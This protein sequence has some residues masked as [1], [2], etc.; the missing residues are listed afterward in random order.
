MALILLSI[1]YLTVPALILY[2]CKKSSLIRKI[3]SIVVAYGVGILMGLSGLLPDGSAQLQDIFISG[4]I[5]LAIPLLLFPTK[6]SEW[7]ELAGPTLKALAVGMFS[8][9]LTVFIGYFIFKPDESQEFWKVGALLIGVY[10]GGTPN[11]ASLKVMLDV[12]NDTYLVVHSYDMIFGSI[13]FFFLITIGHRFFLKILPPFR[14]KSGRKIVYHEEEPIFDKLFQKEATLPLLKVFGLALLIL[15]VSAGLASL[16]PESYFMIVVILGL[17]TLALAASLIPGVNKIEKSFDLGMYFIL[18][19]SVSVASMVNLNDLIHASIN[20]MFYPAFVIF[21]SLLVQTIISRFTKTDADTLM[22]TST[23][24]ICSPPF[25]PVV[26]SAIK[27]RNILVP[28]ITVGVIGYAVGN[29]LGFI[30]GEILR[31][32]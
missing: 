31:L 2:F 6:I 29:Y 19:F 1:F 13:Y 21:G 23:A 28:G 5:P 8:V 18:V 26:C 11:L 27:N 16:F 30:V 3:G 10:T 9:V 25:V 7:F 15:A 14:M 32:L 22:I 20:L 17:S 24:L 12:A 4:S